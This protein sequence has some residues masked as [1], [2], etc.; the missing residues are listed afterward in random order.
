LSKEKL[1]VSAWLGVDANDNSNADAS[2]STMREVIIA[3]I[4]E[5]SVMPVQACT[6]RFLRQ[7]S[8]PSAPRPEAKSGS[9]AG[10]GVCVTVPLDVL[11]TN[12]EEEVIWARDK[13][14]MPPD[15]VTGP[16]IIRAVSVPKPMQPVVLQSFPISN[17]PEGAPPE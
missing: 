10:S 5:F 2:I 4:G 12:S 7:P 3:S 6:F 1:N 15:S 17:R 8:R 9:V 13:F 14:A 16:K 11:K